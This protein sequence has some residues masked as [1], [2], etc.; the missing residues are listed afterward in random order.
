MRD[1]EFR[2]SCAKAQGQKLDGS[3]HSEDESTHEK[4]VP[5]MYQDLPAD[6]RQ[7]AFAW[8]KLPDKIKHGIV[9]QVRD[10]LK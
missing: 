10:S 5:G 9:A 1:K 8:E 2:N 6:L 7:V 3:M 4:Y